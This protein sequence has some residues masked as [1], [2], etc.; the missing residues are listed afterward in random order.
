M[1]YAPRTLGL[2]FAV[3]VHHLTARDVLVVTRLACHKAY[4]VAT[5]IIYKRFHEHEPIEGLAATVIFW[6]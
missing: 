5:L 3:R 1:P 4:W 2:K 6:L